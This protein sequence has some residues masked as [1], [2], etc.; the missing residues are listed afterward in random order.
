MSQVALFVVS[1]SGFGL[2]LRWDE[3]FIGADGKMSILEGL[4][5]TSVHGLLRLVVPRWAYYLRSK[6]KRPF[7]HS[8]VLTADK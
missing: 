4:R 2:K 1:S 8:R 6:S 7:P 5:I 3:S